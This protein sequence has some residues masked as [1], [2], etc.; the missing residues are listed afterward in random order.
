M[1]DDLLAKALMLDRNCSDCISRCIWTYSDSVKI[2]YFCNFP[3]RPS[4]LP[5][6]NICDKWE[7]GEIKNE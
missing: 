6:E 7:D 3:D 5:E 1:K 4:K 2:D